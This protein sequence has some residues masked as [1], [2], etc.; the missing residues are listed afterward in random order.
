MVSSGNSI[1]ATFLSWIDSADC[2]VTVPQLCIVADSPHQRKKYHHSRYSE[3]DGTMTEETAVCEGTFTRWRY[4]GSCHCGLTEYICYLNLPRA[5]A[6]PEAGA[7]HTR[8]RKCNCTIFHKTSSF[9][10]RLIDAP[11]DFVLLSPSD[12]FESMTSYTG[13]SRMAHWFLC[14]TIHR[15]RVLCIKRRKRRNRSDKV[16]R[17][18]ERG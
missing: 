10:L 17:E 13:E 5:D 9:S 15:V 14:R 8:I 11:N 3:A 7:E 1:V 4:H 18:G 16:S 2:A 12:P 6:S